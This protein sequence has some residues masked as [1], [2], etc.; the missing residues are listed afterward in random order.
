L[1]DASH[2]RGWWLPVTASSDKLGTGVANPWAAG[3][4]PGRQC[5]FGAGAY[6]AILERGNQA[7]ITLEGQ[8]IEQVTQDSEGFAIQHF[9][10]NL[11]AA[12]PLTGKAWQA[13]ADGH[14]QHTIEGCARQAI[15]SV[16]PIE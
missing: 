12:H 13:L 7:S 11:G 14:L 8:D 9:H 1:L 15:Q 3:G 6:V 5:Q 4:S 10:H 2:E 16:F